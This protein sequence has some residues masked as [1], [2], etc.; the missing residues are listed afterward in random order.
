M[1]FCHANHIAAVRLWLSGCWQRPDHA[2]H[3][4]L[5]KTNNHQVNMQAFKCAS[6]RQ[7]SVAACDTSS[8]EQKHVILLCLQV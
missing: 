8:A 1:P 7:Y 4:K 3:A 5:P 2:L 6:F